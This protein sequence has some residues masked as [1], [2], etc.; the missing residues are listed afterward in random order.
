MSKQVKDPRSTP[1]WKRLRKQ[2]YERDK[3]A[4]A[5]CWIGH[6]PINYNAKP[7]STPD[8]YEPDHYY[9]VATHPELAL[10]P[11]NVRPACKACNRAR[12]TKAGVDNI[13][14]RSRRW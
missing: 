2:C 14:N 9:P 7:S 12:Q 13:G 10:M 11:E 5:E 1:Q 8:S 4:N 6:H 3:A